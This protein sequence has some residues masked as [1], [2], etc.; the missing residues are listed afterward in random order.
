MVFPLSYDDAI[1]ENA[2]QM[3][4]GFLVLTDV[5]QMYVYSS[6]FHLKKRNKMN[7]LEQI[8]FDQRF[9]SEVGDVKGKPFV[10]Q[11]A[12]ERDECGRSRECVP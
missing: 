3:Q 11:F 1:V 8:L 6:C 12:H 2:R 9:N 4:T 5:F 7:S 10:F